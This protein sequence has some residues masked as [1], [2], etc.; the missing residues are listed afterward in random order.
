M[1]LYLVRHAETKENAEGIAQGHS[2]GGRLSTKGR[3]QTL[4]ISEW[5]K[6]EHF[7]YAYTSDLRRAVETAGEILKHHPTAKFEATSYLRERKMGAYEGR[8]RE[9]F[10][11]AL[12]RSKKPFHLFRARGAESYA[13]LQKRVVRFIS[14]LIKKHRGQNVL[15]VS[16]GAALGTLLLHLLGKPL[17]RENYLRHL[18]PNA[19]LSIFELND[20]GQFK[21]RFLNST[22]HLTGLKND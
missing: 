5:L 19:A 8:P 11:Q 2:I 21:S 9:H 7:H 16:H 3:F 20:Q 22:D 1:R 17:N 15:I 14:G 10:K 4:K 13:D 6:G 18:P 12:R